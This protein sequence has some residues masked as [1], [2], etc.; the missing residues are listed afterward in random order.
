VTSTNWITQH[1]STTVAET[2]GV[3]NSTAPTQISL[4]GS[5]TAAGKINNLYTG[6]NGGTA[7]SAGTNAITISTGDGNSW[8]SVIIPNS[9]VATTLGTTVKFDN[10]PKTSAVGLSGISASD[11]YVMPPSG[12]SQ[13]VAFLGTFSLNASTGD[14]QFTT[15]PEPSTYAA[16]LGAA[17]LAFVAIRRAWNPRP[18]S[19]AGRVARGGRDCLRP[20]RGGQ[21]EQT[22]EA[23]NLVRSVLT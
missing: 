17:T 19:R 5:S 10:L 13:P 9:S 12:F 4:S 21:D 8:N 14:F 18:C 1:V 2:L 22:L 3:K 15:I 23:R 6:I 20:D 16:I 7:T 11:L